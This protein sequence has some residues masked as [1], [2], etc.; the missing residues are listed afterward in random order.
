MRVT[1]ETVS[2]LKNGVSCGNSYKPS[3]D[4]IP[5]SSPDSRS[6]DVRK[7]SSS[8][9]KRRI[10]FRPFPLSS[11]AFGKTLPDTFQ[12]NSRVSNSDSLFISL[13]AN[14]GRSCTP[15]SKTS[16]GGS[17]D[18]TPFHRISNVC[19]SGFAGLSCNHC[20]C[21]ISSQPELTC[22]FCK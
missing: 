1:V 16:S 15:S 10:S 22:I 9:R 13:T 11:S 3:L 7:Y 17:T 18:G 14:D 20:K 2:I 6:C 4:S 5:R 21:F 12:E 19:P 8:S